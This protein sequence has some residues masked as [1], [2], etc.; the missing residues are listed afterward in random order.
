MPPNPAATIEQFT[1]SAILMVVLLNPF[2]MSIYLIG[3]FRQLTRP[4]LA[5][6]LARAAL[7]SGAM[8]ALFAVAGDTI[9]RDVLQVRFAAFLIFGGIVF[10]VIAVRFVQEGGDAIVVLRGEPRHL[11]GSI[12][13][14]FMVGPGTVSASVLAG[15]R[16]PVWAAVGSLALGLMVTVACVLGL[17]IIHDMVAQRNEALVQRYIEIVGRISALVVGTIAVEMILRGLDQ[18]MQNI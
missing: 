18:W 17:K 15:S 3:L 9:F 6:V 2:L 1:E 13:M 4:V 7:I 5:S 11:A 14:P 10:L 8:F 16:L 12:A